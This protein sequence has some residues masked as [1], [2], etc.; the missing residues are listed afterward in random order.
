M[1]D[2]MMFRYAYCATMQ[3]TSLRHGYLVSHLLRT[4]P[5]GLGHVKL[6][7]V[8]YLHGVYGVRALCVRYST[9]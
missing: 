1:N 6:F 5:G 2:V 4:V 8:H 9:V 7:G 3:C